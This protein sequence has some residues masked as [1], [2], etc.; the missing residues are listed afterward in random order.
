MAY[1]HLLCFQS[2]PY[3]LAHCGFRVRSNNTCRS[4]FEH[5]AFWS[6]EMFIVARM[7]RDKGVTNL[8]KVRMDS[9]DLT[10]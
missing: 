10:Q 5:I 9:R 1:L 3:G 2:A 6:R 4:G 7:E 8:L